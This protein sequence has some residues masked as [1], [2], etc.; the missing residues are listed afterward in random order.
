M[1]RRR[2]TLMA[3]L[4]CPT[5]AEVPFAQVIEFRKPEAPAV[6]EDR[7]GP[8]LARE[9]EPKLEDITRLDLNAQPELLPLVRM[10]DGV[11][12]MLVDNSAIRKPYPG[13]ASPPGEPHLGSLCT[14]S[15]LGEGLVA[16]ADHCLKNWDISRAIILRRHFFKIEA[17]RVTREGHVDYRVEGD[18]VAR[19]SDLTILR[20]AESEIPPPE[21]TFEMPPPK[22]PFRPGTGFYALGFPNDYYAVPYLAHGCAILRPVRSRTWSREFVGRCEIDG[23]MSGGPQALAAEPSVQIGV[24]S[25]T[26]GDI[27]PGTVATPRMQGIFDEEEPRRPPRK[28]P[29]DSNQ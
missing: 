13:T 29:P 14:A 7:A 24:N 4:V 16:T 15:Y 9:L 28:R 17:G 21:T 10:L 18:F 26:Q 5:L 2:A 8:A 23:G 11:F 6:R 22:F 25:S 12:H 27:E 19:K 1:L 20:L 3:F